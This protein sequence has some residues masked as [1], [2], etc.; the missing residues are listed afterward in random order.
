MA[1][2]PRKRRIAIVGLLS[3]QINVIQRELGKDVVILPIE[4][5]HPTFPE[6]DQVVVMTK[7]V[8]HG[9]TSAFVMRYG[10]ENVLLCEGG[11]SSLKKLLTENPDSGD[12]PTTK[13]WRSQ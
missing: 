9:H 2:E 6:A 11:L 10:R 5:E 13:A 7:F 8:R 1:D 3:K 4:R 12:P